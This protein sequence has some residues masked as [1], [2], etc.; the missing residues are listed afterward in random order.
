VV[1]T[2]GDALVAA[3]FGGDPA[4]ANLSRVVGEGVAALVIC[5]GGAVSVNRLPALGDDGAADS[6]HVVFAIDRVDG[7]VFVAH[8]FSGLARV[9]SIYSIEDDEFEFFT[10][11]GHAVR[12]TAADGRAA[13]EVT[14]DNRLGDLLPHLRRFATAKELDVT[15][16]N[17]DDPSA[18]V[19]P[20]EEWQALELWPP[21]LRPIGRLLRALR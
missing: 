13:F 12:A 18:Y 11:G 14:D 5:L 21:W 2:I 3:T 16:E 4:V 10:L 8:S 20:I 6:Q 1:G 19:T 17:R 9:I 15:P 7:E